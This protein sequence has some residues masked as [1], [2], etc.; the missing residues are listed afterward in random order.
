MSTYA[1][2]DIQGCYQSLRK[3]LNK[4]RFN[5]CK[6]R[7]ILA[8]DLINRGPQSLETMEFILQHQT[9]IYCVLGNHDLHFLAVANYCKSPNS[10]D[11]FN[12]ILQS[13]LRDRIAV[14]LSKQPLA[15]YHKPS[16]SLISH[17]GLPF[18]W[19]VKQALGYS[20]E[21]SQVLQSAA[22]YQFYVSMYGNK[23]N[24]WNEDLKGV[25]RLR[26]ITNAFTRMRYC[27]SSGQLDLMVKSSPENQSSEL[28]PWFELANSQ[29]KGHIIF[30][31]WA[32][33]QGKSHYPN[34]HPIDTGCVWGGQ[35]TAIRL[36]DFKRT[37]VN[38]IEAK[39]RKF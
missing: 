22:R 17:A 30:G 18:N 28:L 31:H 9:S 8:G 34:I 33:L 13:N 2:G 27:D 26:Y 32:S 16:N 12:D 35:L 10:K 5:P 38:S 15:I 3:L 21:V 37:F 23:P 11:T 19:S 29:L 6:D 7:L 39:S 4:I 36:E 20:R 1:I 14:W 24:S 25:D